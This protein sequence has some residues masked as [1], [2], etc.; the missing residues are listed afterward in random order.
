MAVDHH[1][2]IPIGSDVNGQKL[3]IYGQSR[4][5]LIDAVDDALENGEARHQLL[6]GF[7]YQYEFTPGDYIFG[8]YRKDI[9]QPIKSHP[10]LGRITPN[11]FV[12]TL[13]LPIYRKADN[14]EID[15]LPIEVRSGK[16]GYRKD[17]RAM[18]EFITKQCVDLLLQA[19]SV[20]SQNLTHDF[21]K[22]AK[23]E[24]LYQR[25]MFVK[26]VVDSEEF[27]EAVQRILSAPVTRWTETVEEK[28]VRQAGRLTSANIREL[29]KGGRRIPVALGHPLR[30][31][32]FDSIPD[33]IRVTHK[34]DSVDTTENR[35]VKHA[36]EAFLEF[37]ED[38]EG[39]PKAGVATK[40]EARRLAEHI[41]GWL[42]H[43]VFRS[44]SRVT[45]LKLNSPVL[46]RKAGYREVLNAWLLFD[47]AAKL[48]WSG[49]DDVYS[50]GKKDVATLYEYWL[51]FK[52]LDLMRSMYQI[53]PKELDQ[54]IQ[55]SKDGMTLSLRQGDEV[56]IRGICD[57]NG[58]KLNI[59]FSYNRM[60]KGAKDYPK[61]GSWTT[62]MR[63]DYTLSI[64][65]IGIEDVEAERQ[66]LIVHVHF[67][68]K[69]KVENYRRMISSEKEDVQ[70]KV[71][72]RK[73]NYKNADLL[74]M[75]AYKDAIRRTGGAYVLYPGRVP[76]ERSGFRE[77]VPGL[78]AFPIRPKEDDSGIEALKE[79][80]EDLT[81]HF[82]NRTSQ[83]EK[84]AYRTYDI[85]QDP[86]SNDFIIREPL[87]ETYD[88]K[89]GL[90]PDETYVLVGYYRSPA[91]LKWI[92]DKKLYNFRTGDHEEG[93]LQLGVEEV[94][95]KY[96][97]LHTGDDLNANILLK[98]KPIGLKVV[99]RAEMI[100]L[101]YPSDIVRD[102]YLVV[103]VT[104]DI[105]NELTGKHWDLSRLSK[106]NPHRKKGVP[107]TTT[108]EE[109][110]QE[111]KS[112]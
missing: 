25:F 5:S 12:G 2:E 11:I 91:H 90:I 106:F 73:G 18:L 98:I 57:R 58:R 107:F 38:V 6:E 93:A 3:I 22:D 42:Q 47:L 19:E 32:S 44:Q 36:L 51:F 26:S 63:P 105:E 82:V 101:G 94:T 59:Q 23:D 112:S 64:W 30:E 67:D 37:C 56:A 41:E 17:Y 10:H 61:E 96:L 24:I 65:P 7:E 69:Y 87:P 27:E 85:H 86:P 49:G 46:Q 31:L 102:Q 89:R 50:A 99:E 108:L 54:L 104:E 34:I 21:D 35:F 92:L 62:T 76:V 95:A 9:I 71:E 83:R 100:E 20:V 103:S 80:L 33:R 109:L 68:A 66:E 13:K 70:E 29:I 45:L 110:F 78:G 55:E 43:D 72:N 79:F 1:L 28:N 74:K 81:D 77:I 39:A 111:L 97:L 52:L 15:V 75:H 60:F 14:T 53:E 4:R 16:T 48:I 88:D 84:M 40:A 8:P